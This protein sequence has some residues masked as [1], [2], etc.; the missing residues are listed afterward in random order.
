MSSLSRLLLSHLS[1]KSVYCTHRPLL[2]RTLSDDGKH[3]C[4]STEGA[5]KIHCKNEKL[6]EN[7][8]NDEKPPP[9][10]MNKKGEIIY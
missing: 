5:K 3:L 1:K 4:Y 2:T 9:T 7:S 6:S 8:E 10:N